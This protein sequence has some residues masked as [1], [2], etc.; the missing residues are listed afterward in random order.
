MF[1]F[2]THKLDIIEL[3]QKEDILWVKLP[4]QIQAGQS[5]VC[6]YLILLHVHFVGGL[7]CV[8]LMWCCFVAN[9]FLNNK[10]CSLFLFEK[11]LGNIYNTFCTILIVLSVILHIYI[12]GRNWLTKIWIRIIEFGW[13]NRIVNPNFLFGFSK[14]RWSFEILYNNK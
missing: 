4:A 9:L 8:W 1:T 6:C 13:D 12:F 11:N 10:Q 2:M 5:L 3:S 7:G 14:S